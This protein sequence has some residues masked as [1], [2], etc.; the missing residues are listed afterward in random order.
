MPVHFFGFFYK[1]LIF[2]FWF[3]TDD[4]QKFPAECTQDNKGHCQCGNTEEGFTTYTFKTS[5]QKR[6]FTVYHPLS[7]KDEALPVVISA[8]CYARSQLDAQ[9]Y[10]MN[11]T[12]SAR[13][14]AAAKYGY[15]RIAISSP[16]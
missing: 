7:R 11:D 16:T 6:C 12:S 3:S 8:Q 10:E 9:W 15:A 4:E 13:N 1:L 14:K 5:G 2:Y